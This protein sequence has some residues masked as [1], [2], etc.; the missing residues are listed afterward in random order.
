VDLVQLSGYGNEY[1]ELAGWH[2]EASA[3]NTVVSSKAPNLQVRWACMSNNG[4]ITAYTPAVPA[5]PHTWTAAD[6]LTGSA[7]GGAKVP[8][9]TELRDVVRFL[10]NPPCFR[11]HC[12]GS[13]Q[14]IPLGA[15]TWTAFT[16]TGESLDPYGMWS[17]GAT[18]TCQRAGLYYIAGLAAVTETATK[19]GYR[20]CRIHHTI[21]AGGSADYYGASSV[22]MSSTKT[23]GTSLLA[24]ANIRM[25]AGDTLQLQF[26]HTNGSALPVL[27]TSA[28]VSA[29]MIGVWMAK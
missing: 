15:G 11:V 21:A 3:V 27:G 13:A 16:F 14:T 23:T 7:T 18:V 12:S 29:R 9:N 25:A 17:S 22:P 10:N 1:I 4:V 2:N 28:L 19:A 24:D 8:L 26:D 6:V 20:A 5:A